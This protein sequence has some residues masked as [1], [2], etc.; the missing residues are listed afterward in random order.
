MFFTE[1]DPLT[2]E[3]VENALRLAA[4][5]GESTD[6]SP[7]SFTA[8]LSGDYAPSSLS[9][10]F[11]DGKAV[12]VTL[13]GESYT[14]SYAAVRLGKLVLVTHLIPGTSRGFH[15]VLDRETMA[16]TVFETWFGITVP[17]GLDM[18][19]KRPPQSYRDIPR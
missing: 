9:Y 3:Y 10:A 6:L 1:Y 13:D 14:A 4:P 17:V 7:L 2:A 18:T 11:L 8:R 16:L 12:R 15:L 19:G 5:S